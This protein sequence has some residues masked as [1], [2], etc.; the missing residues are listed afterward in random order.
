MANVSVLA[1]QNAIKTAVL[2]ASS[3]EPALPVTNLTNDLGA[4]SAAWQTLAGALSGVLL[5]ITPTIRTTFRTFGV[6][7]T[8]LTSAGTVTARAYTNPGAVPVGTWAMTVVQGQCVAV[9]AADT[10]ADYV[11]FTLTDAAN[12]DNHL[13]I[14]LAYAGPAW[15]PLSALSWTSALGRDDITDTAVSR[16]GQQYFDMRATSRRWEIAMDGVRAAEVFT[17]LDVLDAYSRT[18]GNVL[19]IPDTTSGN[20]QYEAVFG[21]LKATADF[22]WPFG[23]ADR[24]SWRARLTQRL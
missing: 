5:T 15:L 19:V 20:Q 21:A 18:G 9:A 11:T 2:T 10:P 3:A 17:Q 7:Q 16:G 24:R 4:S 8:N 14:P 1:W 12:P 23:A 6:F 13:N 22:A